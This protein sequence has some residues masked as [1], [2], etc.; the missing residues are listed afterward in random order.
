MVS[1]TFTADVLLCS[2]NLSWN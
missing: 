1:Y 2:H